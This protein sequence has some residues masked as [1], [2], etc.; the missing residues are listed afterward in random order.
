[1]TD[2][3]PLLESIETTFKSLTTQIT[4]MSKVTRVLQDELKS[5]HKMVKQCDKSNKTKPKRPQTK[6]YLSNDLEKFL[7]VDKGTLLTKAEVMK[8]VS[9]YIK[10]KNLQIQED[11]RKFIPNKEL[12]KIFGIKK[13]QN[14]T[15]VE[16]N[17]HVSP[18]LSQTA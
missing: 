2:K 12:S 7:S 4:D 9:K 13:P 10:E 8:S 11:K 17:K 6:M 14:M 1:M 3:L 5:L 15:F 18:H 16:I